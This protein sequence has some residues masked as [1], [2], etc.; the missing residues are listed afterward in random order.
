[1]KYC[2]EFYEQQ[3][4]LFHKKLS[5]GSIDNNQIADLQLSGPAQFSSNQEEIIEQ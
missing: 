3:K 2:Q 1:M 5:K 4:K